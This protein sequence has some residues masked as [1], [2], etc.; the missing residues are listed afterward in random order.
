MELIL[1][2]GLEGGPC[3]HCLQVAPGKFC[4]GIAQT[5]FISLSLLVYLFIYFI[6]LK[7]GKNSTYSRTQGAS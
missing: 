7:D 6:S 3:G 5:Q 2:G 1:V 4:S